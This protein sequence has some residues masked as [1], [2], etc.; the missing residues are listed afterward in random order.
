MKV[1][2]IIS[3]CDNRLEL[4]HRSL[5]TW[6]N[7]SEK[8]FELVLVDDGNH[9]DILNL[10]KSYSLNFQYIKIDNS[11]CAVPITTFTPVLSNNVG[12]KQARG[13]VICITGPETLQGSKNIEIAYTFKDRKECGYGLIYKSNK[14]FVDYIKNNW[15]KTFTD[16]LLIPG[17]QANCLTK[18]PHPI[19]YYYFLTIKKKF[20]E[21][22]GGLDEK[23]GQGYT[24]ED[25]DIG[26][27]LEMFGINPVFEHKIIGIHQDHSCLNTDKHVDRYKNQELKKRNHKL[28]YENL[29]NKQIVANIGHIWG[30]PK[31]IIYHE[32]F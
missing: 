12:I 31:T 27:R 19:R 22:V 26:N 14:Q 20:L 5:D 28:M 6:A 24:A 30:D 25:D 11:L 4:F 32:V 10:C 29:N 9:N 21:I 13:E 2:V 8:D 15:K 18:P 3:L 17:A 23:F 1:S 16:L 7:Q